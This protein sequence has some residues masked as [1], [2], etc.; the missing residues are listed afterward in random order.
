MNISRFFGRS[1]TVLALAV[2]AVSAQAAT[3]T[4]T[5]WTAVTAGNTG[6]ATG[7][8][9]GTTVSYSGQVGFL[10]TA[11]SYTPVATFT[12]GVV[13]NAPPAAFRSVALTGGLAAANTITFSQPVTNPVMAIWSLGQPGLQASF[14]FNAAEPFTLQSGGPNAEFGGASITVSGNNVMGSEGN[15]VIL[16]NGTFSSLTFTNPTFENYYTFT[17]GMAGSTTDVPEPGS[18]ALLLAGIGG[19][20][21]I[22][23]KR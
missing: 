8:M 22:R 9:G 4:W 10:A 1:A 18:V 23:R 20:L 11:P 21:I 3:I 19:V 2:V 14:N 6:T 17:V 12:G 5:N 16:F 7:T 13:G 15:G